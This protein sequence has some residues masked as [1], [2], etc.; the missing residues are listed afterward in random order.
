MY[1]RLTA[2]VMLLAL[3]CGLPARPSY[4]TSHSTHTTHCADCGTP[5]SKPV[6]DDG[7]SQGCPATLACASFTPMQCV[8]V[9]PDAGALRVSRTTSDVLAQHRLS[10]TS[11]FHPPR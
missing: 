1:K 9:T 10:I 6:T 7:C 4:A 3:L 11:I 2:L 8:A 5:D